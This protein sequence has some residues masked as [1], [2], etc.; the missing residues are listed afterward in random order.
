MRRMRN[1]TR[2]S[3]CRRLTTAHRGPPVRLRSPWP[4]PDSCQPEWA[5]VGLVVGDE[6]TDFPLCSQTPTNN[7]SSKQHERRVPASCH[8]ITFGR[9]ASSSGYLYASPRLYRAVEQTSGEAVADGMLISQIEPP[10][11][12]RG[13]VSDPQ[14]GSARRSVYF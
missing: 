2:T 1:T 4:T 7:G 12:R 13:D 3:R 9:S 5:R 6:P 8:G 14:I 11:L 10:L